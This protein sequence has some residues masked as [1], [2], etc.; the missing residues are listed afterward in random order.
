MAE[1]AHGPVK[2]FSIGFA[3]EAVNEL[4]RARVIA[5]RFS[6][7][8]NELVVEPDAIE[9]LP[10]I[11]RHYGEPFGDHSALPCFYLAELAR[12]QV[13]VALNGDGGDESFAG[14]QRYTTNTLAA[15]LERL[16]ASLRGAIA[17]AGSRVG[18]TSNPR[19]LRSRAHRFTARLGGERHQRY[20]RQVEVFRP[21]ERGALLSADFAAEVGATQAESVILDVWQQASGSDLLDQLLEVDASVYLPGD[22]LTKI[23]IATMAYS[24]EAR[25]PLLD[26]EFMELAASI[27]PQHKARGLQRKVALKGALRSWL[28]ETTLEGPKKGFELPVAR[29]LRT[30]LAPLARE[31]LLD[32]QSAER[33]WTRTAEVE[34]MLDLH[35]AGAAD[36]GRKLWSLLV[37]ELWA[38][39]QAETAPELAV[40]VA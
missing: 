31:I 35:V 22:L 8:H 15:R 25:S 11:V 37:L 36:H 6:T 12:E 16:P 3:D 39:S 32:R 4:P 5:D 13:T 19:A 23:D 26:H 10:K 9:L 17:A 24:L 21:E 7:D 20:L 18:G 30:D 14:Y 27:P 1:Q 29:W 28:P 33:G 38:Q 34:K 40:A 2:T